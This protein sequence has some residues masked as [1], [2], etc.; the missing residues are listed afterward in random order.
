M[1]GRT[2][3]VA[4]NF[5]LLEEQKRVCT[6]MY[7]SSTQVQCG[8]SLRGGSITAAPAAAAS[9]KL[10]NALSLSSFQPRRGG[11][12]KKRENA[13]LRCRPPA[14]LLFAVGTFSLS[15]WLG[16]RPPRHQSFIGG[17]TDCTFPSRRSTG[18]ICQ[19]HQTFHFFFLRPLRRPNRVHLISMAI[20]LSFL[21][22]ELCPGGPY[23]VRREVRSSGHPSPFLLPFFRGCLSFFSPGLSLSRR[24]P[25]RL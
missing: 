21:L 12:R 16:R 19:V 15:R 14:L 18:Q 2:K 3:I 22:P 24:R 5:L 10:T 1:W 9:H 7:S 23:V 20:S 25:R 8:S 17:R 11:V 13:F 4:G 6:S